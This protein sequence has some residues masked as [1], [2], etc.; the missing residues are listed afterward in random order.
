MSRWGRAETREEVQYEALEVRFVTLG[1][2]EKVVFGSVLQN[3][4]IEDI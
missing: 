3:Y 4:L 1:G 2:D